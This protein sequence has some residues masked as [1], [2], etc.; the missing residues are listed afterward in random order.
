[1]FY[2]E[3]VACKTVAITLFVEGFHQMCILI[4]PLNACFWVWAVRS[5]HF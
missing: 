3:S 4:A 1:M 2:Q 5:S